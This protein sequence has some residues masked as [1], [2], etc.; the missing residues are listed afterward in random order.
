ME[1]D[2]NV[3]IVRAEVVAG[4]VK[5]EVTEACRTCPRYGRRWGCPPLS[6]EEVAAVEGCGCV[7]LIGIEVPSGTDLRELRARVEP[8]LLEYERR[9][10]GR[11][12]APAGDCP[13][14]PAGEVCARATGD[15]CRHPERV[16][17]SLEALGV[18]VTELVRDVFGRELAWGGDRLFIVGA[19][20]LPGDSFE[21][22]AQLAA[23]VSSAIGRL[24]SWSRSRDS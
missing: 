14:C 15:A 22:E 19:L 23:S 20:F 12:A 17:P 21:M 4:H 7:V 11:M 16:R 10:G 2:C 18:D 13:Y 24:A 8:L 3:R 6:G 1:Y 5:T 9:T